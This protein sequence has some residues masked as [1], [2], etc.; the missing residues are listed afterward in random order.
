MQNFPKIQNLASDLTSEVAPLSSEAG[1]QIPQKSLE[2]SLMFKPFIFQGKYNSQNSVK[3]SL[4][5]SCL[6]KMPPKSNQISS[7]VWSVSLIS[8]Y[9]L[10]V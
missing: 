3:T 1:S 8:H 10:L 7:Y 2:F 6:I 5:A 9:K 4:S